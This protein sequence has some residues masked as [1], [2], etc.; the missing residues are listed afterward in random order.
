MMKLYVVPHDGV[1]AIPGYGRQGIDVLGPGFTRERFADLAAKH[2]RKQVR[3]F[4]RDHSAMSAIGN[5]YADE[6]LF[7]AQIHPKTF[8]GALTDDQLETLFTSIRTVLQSGIEAVERAR[9]P[10]QQKVRGHLKV[11]NRKG[12]PCPR[13]GTKIR[14]EGVRGHDVFFC[15]A[16]QPATRKLFLDWRKIQAAGRRT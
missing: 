10:I 9:Q 14:R 1:P 6:I 7:D 2:R 11:R 12:E 15:P 16:C 3:V 13:C 8:V 4:L 5:A